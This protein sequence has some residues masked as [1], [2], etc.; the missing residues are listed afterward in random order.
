MT[1]GTVLHVLVVRQLMSVQTL[2][3]M[4]VCGPWQADIIQYLS[5]AG[6][7]TCLQFTCF[8]CDI[9]SI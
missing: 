8:P 9:S 7:C 6:F 4:A 1:A 2:G 5:W 3:S